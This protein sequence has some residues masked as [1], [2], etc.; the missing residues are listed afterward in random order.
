MAH[1]KPNEIE[2]VG[3]AWRITTAATAFIAELCTDDRVNGHYEVWRAFREG[4]IR[5][6][7]IEKVKGH[8]TQAKEREMLAKLREQSLELTKQ[9]AQGLSVDRWVSWLA[10]GLLAGFQMRYH[11]ERNPNDQQKFS[12]P[13]RMLRDAPLGRRPRADG[14]DIERNVRWFYRV[15]VKQ[16]ADTVHDIA[17]DYGSWANRDNDCRSVVQNGI[18]QIESILDLVAENAVVELSDD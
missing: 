8:V 3:D 1:S 13:V 15:K 17:K 6:L 10:P 14:Q 12:I 4:F 9:A 18:G 16:P 11:N 5:L 7:A 2:N